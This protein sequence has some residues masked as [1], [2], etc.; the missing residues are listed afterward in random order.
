ML[1][2]GHLLTQEPPARHN[3]N[4][5]RRTHGRYHIQS[6]DWAFLTSGKPL[7]LWTPWASIFT[8]ARSV[9]TTIPTQDAKPSHSA[10]ISSCLRE[11]L[12]AEGSALAASGLLPS[13]DLRP[14]APGS[15]LLETLADRLPAL[16]KSL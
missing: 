11:T 4:P 9:L 10:V 2:S 13:L 6:A 14:D 12:I 3:V 8:L 16:L 1:L 7:P 15:E 5:A